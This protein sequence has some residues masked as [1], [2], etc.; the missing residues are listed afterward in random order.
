[1][2][3]TA[4]VSYESPSRLG[5][6]LVYATKS[7]VTLQRPDK[8]KIISL[9]DGPPSEFY[10]D[11]K[12][13]MAFAPTENLVAVARRAADHRRG[14]ASGVRL[15]GDLLSVHRR[16]RRR[17]LQG[18]RGRTEGRVLHRPVERRRRHDDG[19]G[20]VRDR[21]RVRADLDRRAGQA[22]APRL[23]RV[24]HRPRAAAP[25]CWSYPTGNW[26]LPFPRMH[27]LPPRRRA[28]THRVCAAGCEGCARDEAAAEG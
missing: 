18:H 23:C 10:Y 25:R 28:R 26:M 3:F 1:M 4:V 11:G 7:E 16:H 9:G 27:L 2:A 8:L 5:P 22:S 20:G 24:P 6:P 21:R 12:V 19:H 17:S 13:M 14:I 15:R